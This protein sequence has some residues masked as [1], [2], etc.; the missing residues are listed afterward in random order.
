M[1][2]YEDGTPT[3][4][5]PFQMKQTYLRMSNISKR[6]IFLGAYNQCIYTCIFTILTTQIFF[7][8]K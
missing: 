2:K 7:T 4:T 6:T 8:L 5:P 3:P 1:E